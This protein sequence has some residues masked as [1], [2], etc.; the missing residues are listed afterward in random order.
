M[1]RTL[2]RQVTLMLFWLGLVVLQVLPAYAQTF[3][4]IHNF[5]GPPDGGV[6]YTSLLYVNGALDDVN[7]VPVST[8]FGTTYVGG[9]GNCTFEGL[10]EGCGVVF[11]ITGEK[12]SVLYSFQGEPDGA[13]PIGDLVRD[14]SG[15]LYGTTG[16]GGSYNYGTVFRISG[17]KE[18]VLYSFKGAP[19]GNGP[20]G[21]VVQDVAGNF[22]GTTYAGGTNPA[23][24]D[25]VDAGTVFKLD[26]NQKET[27]LYSFC[28]RALCADG[29]NPQA[30]VIMDTEGNLYGTTVAG[31]D[32][33][34]GTVFK[35]D[36]RSG[37]ETVLYSFCPDPSCVDGESP[38]AGVV[39]DARGNLYGTTTGGGTGQ[40]VIFKLDSSGEEAVLY[41]FCSAEPSCG[42]DFPIAGLIMDARENLYGTAS[43][44]GDDGGGTVFELDTSGA[45]SI[46][47]TF[48]EFPGL[49][50]PIGGLVMDAEGNLYGTAAQ[51]GPGNCNQ[52]AFSGCGAVF[53]LKP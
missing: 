22:Y 13:F 43:A 24:G 27:V 44:G 48:S 38:Q 2:A 21:A 30:G 26:V 18:T 8:F 32:T 3:T 12:E 15:N 42:G 7:F 14:V 50:E 45:F 11:A 40:G 39:M 28:S 31:G 29:A 41:T 34:S 19:D 25:P 16:A 23:N 52:A 5:A 51:G 9:T 49:L 36:P 1:R 35:L 20:T 6:P 10:P 53:K 37:A 33:D 4:A 17:K 46:L 47:H